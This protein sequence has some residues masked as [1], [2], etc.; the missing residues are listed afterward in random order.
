MDISFYWPDD[1]DDDGGENLCAIIRIN[2]IDVA[3]RALRETGA[4]V[5]SKEGSI[6]AEDDDLGILERSQVF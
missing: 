6:S 4:N 1:D 5:C 3:P 2:R